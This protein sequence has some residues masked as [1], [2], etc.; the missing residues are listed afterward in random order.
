M[1]KTFAQLWEEVRPC[2][3]STGPIAEAEAMQLIK[4]FQKVFNIIKADFNFSA[5]ALVDRL[6]HPRN[7]PPISA[8]EFEFV[9]TKFVQKMSKQLQDDVWDVANRKV[10][11]RGKRT[12]NIRPNNYEYGITSKSTGLAIVLALQPNHKGR[13]KV[14]VNIITVM[15][16]H[17]FGINQGEHIMVEGVQYNFDDLEWIEVD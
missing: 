11:A 12:E 17:G 1:T 8:C 9:M 4:K 6:N 13:N 7:K 14:R 5:H 3:P 15:R 16:K 10:K 2:P